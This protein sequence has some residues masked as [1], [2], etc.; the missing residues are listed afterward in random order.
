[1]VLFNDSI[2]RNYNNNIIISSILTTN[3]N[4]N[5]PNPIT[6]TLTPFV[7]ENLVV[8]LSESLGSLLLYCC[9]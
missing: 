7:E 9:I 3:S 2:D 8:F 4:T 6:T 5:Y 1:M